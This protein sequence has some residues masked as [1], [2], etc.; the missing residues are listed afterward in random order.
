MTTTATMTLSPQ[1]AQAIEQTVYRAVQAAL[2]QGI[3]RITRV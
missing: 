1:M 3:P 2:N